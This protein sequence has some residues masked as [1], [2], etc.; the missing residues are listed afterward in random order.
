MSFRS[1]KKEKGSIIGNNNAV[2]VLGGG[3]SP[4]DVPADGGHRNKRLVSPT[5]CA[6]KL[7]IFPLL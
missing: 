7:L 2:G 1:G 4:T 3:R 5:G 6:R